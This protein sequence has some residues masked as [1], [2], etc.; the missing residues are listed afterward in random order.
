MTPTQRQEALKYKIEYCE[1]ADGWV[2]VDIQSGEYITD[3]SDGGWTSEEGA[4]QELKAYIANG[5]RY[6]DEN[7]D[8]IK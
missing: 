1:R 3:I 6:Y 4:E 8:R 5:N 7:G 2:V